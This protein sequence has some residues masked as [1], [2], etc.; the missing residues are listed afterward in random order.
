ML[1]PLFFHPC[2]DGIFL[3][4]YCYGGLLIIYTVSGGAKAVAYTQQLQML[5][6]FIGMFLAGYLIVHY[7][8]EGVGFADALKVSGASGKLNVI[9][10]GFTEKGFDWKDRYNIISGIIGGFFLALSYFGT[11]QSQVGRYLTAKDS[12]E[13]KL[14]LLMNGLVKVP[15]QFLILLLGAMLF[16]FYQFKPAPVFFNQSVIEKASAT[17]YK[18]SLL[19]V[20]NKF[21]QQQAK[22]EQWSRAYVQPGN[23]F[24]KDS[25]LQGTKQMTATQKNTKLSCIKLCHMQIPTIP[26]IYSCVLWWTF[27]Q[28][29]WLVY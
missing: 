27:Y 6:I 17:T 1:L 4:Q 10:T 26:I 12:T 22:Q 3:Y 21:Q 8:P 20:E 14:G 15:M 11:D 5:I 18:D 2:W 29:D 9:T 23:Q 25:L 16:T 28:R 19:Q 7:L 13:S 24:L